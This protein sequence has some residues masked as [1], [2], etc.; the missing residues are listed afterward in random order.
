MNCRIC[1]MAGWFERL[2][3]ERPCDDCDIKDKNSEECENAEGLCEVKDDGEE[4]PIL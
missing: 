4:L 2:F 1:K 3:G